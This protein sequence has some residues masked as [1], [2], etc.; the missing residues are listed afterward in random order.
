MKI[1]LTKSLIIRVIIITSWL[2][3]AIPNVIWYFWYQHDVKLLKDFESLYINDGGDVEGFDSYIMPLNFPVLQMKLMCC[4]MAIVK[5]KQTQMLLFETI[6]IPEDMSAKAY[7]TSLE[8]DLQERWHFAYHLAEMDFKGL[9][10]DARLQSLCGFLLNKSFTEH[11]EW[12]EF[13]DEFSEM[14]VRNQSSGV[15]LSYYQT[16]AEFVG[17]TNIDVDAYSVEMEAYVNKWVNRTYMWFVFIIYT[18]GLMCYVII[19]LFRGE[20]KN[21]V[22]GQRKEGTSGIKN[23]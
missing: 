15:G 3:M 21:A 6:E 8:E 20:S 9:H 12:Q 14:L 16:M 19:D 23:K 2:A 13:C 4:P 18:V 11:E 10:K 1:K 17:Y 5:D 22:K 7:A